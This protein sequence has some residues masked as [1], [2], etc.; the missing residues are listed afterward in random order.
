MK[1]TLVIMA[2][3]MGSRYG[4]DKQVDG[5]GPN[6]EMLMEYSVYD[7]VQA[8]FSKVVFIIKPD[9]EKL[10]R[11]MVDGLLSRLRTKD[12]KPV[13]VAYV[14]QD[15]SS[16]PAFYK[17]PAERTKPF[18]TCHAVLCARREVR[19]PFAVINADDYYGQDAFRTAYDVVTKLPETGHAAMVSYLLKNTVSEHGTV[20]R[21]V[22]TTE[23][24]TLKKVVEMLKVKL[25]PNGDIRDISEGEDTPLLAGDTP[26]SMNFWC[27]TPSI[28]DEIESYFNDFLRAL[29]PEDVKKECLLPVLVDSLIRSGRLAVSVRSSHDRW[30]GMTYQEDKPIVRRALKALHDSGAYPA[31]LG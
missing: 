10:V 15:F 28:F 12:G 7:A 8:G 24:D 25:Y 6:G 5:I 3:G 27:F 22:C 11:G 18:G 23:G 20:S 30:F 14:Y 1:A 29:T 17:I 2:A 4:G 21:G 26:V 9:I 19:E 31:V 13:E 16:V